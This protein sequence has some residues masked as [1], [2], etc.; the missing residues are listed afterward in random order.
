MKS[1]TKNEKKKRKVD[2]IPQSKL[3]IIKR[4]RIKYILPLPF[5]LF[6]F[7]FTFHYQFPLA[8]HIMEDVYQNLIDYH[9]SESSN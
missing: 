6:L 9:E 5:I 2:L 8:C 3:Q 1:S 4:N 7:I